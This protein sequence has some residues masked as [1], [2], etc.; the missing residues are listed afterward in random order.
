MTRTLTLAASLV[1]LTMI[2]GPAS[3]ATTTQNV[4]YG[5]DAFGSLG[6]QSVFVPNST[7]AAMATDAT[8]AYRYHGGPKTND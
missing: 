4:Q 7:D 2:S 8:S 6:Q 1:M 3:A 5:I